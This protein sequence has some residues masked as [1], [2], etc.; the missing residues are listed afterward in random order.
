MAMLARRVLRVLA[1]CLSICCALRG[2]D[3]AAAEEPPQ[4]YTIAVI[5]DSLAVGVGDGLIRV[6]RQ[7][8]HIR[9]LRKAKPSTG[10]TR[11]DVYNWQDRVEE[12]AANESIDAAIIL[13]GTN[14]KQSIYVD[15]NR[16]VAFQTD[17]W[18]RIYE[19]RFDTLVNY[20]IQRNVW[21][22]WM[23]LP[24][25]SNK[26]FDKSMRR[27]DAIYRARSPR[28]CMTFVPMLE[29]TVDAKGEYTASGPD[30]GGKNRA[31]RASDGI[32]FTPTGYDLMAKAVVDAM[33]KDVFTCNRDGR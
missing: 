21:V 12:F 22:I 18:S 10:L 4:P 29:R 17:E 13:M 32:H 28:H 3:A 16:S 14:D 5:G 23:G 8:P 30:S 19:E 6:L 1:I 9:V 24:S 31:L 26:A 25:M 7:S 2:A 20:L 15:H 27:I 33:R 11:F